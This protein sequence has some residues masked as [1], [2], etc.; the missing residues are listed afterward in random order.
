MLP[1]E[2]AR[3]PS[4][5]E[6]VVGDI[7]DPASLDR[8]LNGLDPRSTRVLHLAG[9]VSIASRVSRR[10]RRVNV[11]G[12][13]AVVDACHRH[14][15]SRLVYT[16]SVHAIPDRGRHVVHTEVDHFDPD[17]VHGEY[18]KTKAEATQLVLEA[19]GEQLQTV[20]VHPSG[21]CG[22]GDSGPGAVTSLV[23]A[24]VSGRMRRY[25]DGGHD[26]VDVGDVA[27]GIVAAAEHGRPG[28]GYILSGRYV[29][30]AEAVGVITQAVGRPPLRRLPFWLGVATAPAAEWYFR[31]R[32]QAPEYTPYAVRVLGSHG[33]FSH[34]KATAE[35]GYRPH[36]P[37]DAFRRTALW[38]HQRQA[39]EAP[40]GAA[41]A[42]VA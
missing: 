38:V 23:A 41:G 15:I 17:A 4:G 34:A 40:L 8:L 33:R 16:S 5:V 13:A 14:G 9:I 28:Q 37:A 27:E 30:M 24:I 20:V 22:P 1:G 42:P 36:D 32:H 39:S 31:M 21:V 3:A 11:G 12:T 25:I 35:W 6:L 26:F 18:A 19:N 29:S 7:L 2:Q 10:V